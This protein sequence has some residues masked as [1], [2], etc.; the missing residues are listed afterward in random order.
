MALPEVIPVRY[1]EEEAARWKQFLAAHPAAL[2]LPF[3]VAGTV[4]E[5][6]FHVFATEL[7][8]AHAVLGL[9]KPDFDTLPHATLDQLFG[10]NQDAAGKFREFFGKAKP[11][12]WAQVAP[13]GFGNLKA[14]KR[15]M[16]AQALLH[17]VHHRAQLSTF[18]RQQ[19]FK[20]DWVH[21]FLMSKAME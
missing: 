1:T 6:L 10:I 19:G 21:D 15:K 20:Q 4:R 11:E 17:G 13:L 16:V 5:L 18:L 9:P 8:F 7:F 12:D 2:D 3:D 14:S